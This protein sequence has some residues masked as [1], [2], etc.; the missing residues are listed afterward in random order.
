MEKSTLWIPVWLTL[1]G[2]C[3]GQVTQAPTD[4]GVAGEGGAPADSAA[5]GPAQGGQADS[6]Y[7]ID[8]SDADALWGPPSRTCPE[9][10]C[11][12]SD[13]YFP[14]IPLLRSADIGPDVTF[15]RISQ[16]H[17]L[18]VT[19]TGDVL[20][21]RLPLAPGEPPTLSK[22]P[23]A[24]TLSP[25]DVASSP[26]APAHHGVLACDDGCHVFVPSEQDESVLVAHGAGQVPLPGDPDALVLHAGPD[27][28][29]VFC[30]LGDGVVCIRNGAWEVWVKPGSGPRLRDMALGPE[31]TVLV[32]DG[33]RR[34]TFEGGLQ[35]SNP[36]E[37][38]L[39]PARD[40]ALVTP[41]FW[42]TFLVVGH[43]PTT[44]WSDD[45]DHTWSCEVPSLPKVL[46]VREVNGELHG[47]H[48]GGYPFKETLAEG[49]WTWVDACPPEGAP[50]HGEFID[51]D[52]M[53][54]GAG[55]NYIGLQAKAVFG[56]V[57]CPMVP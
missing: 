31:R 42:D 57:H 1:L 46:A 53:V 45:P 47:V 26:H 17:V 10:A 2:A 38:W 12:P 37:G 9:R 20:T 11:V 36:V 27:Q 29:P 43:D 54:C 7:P 25:K 49:R 14:E 24:S 22:L 30:V 8:G 41:R 40:A 21:A 56:T 51:A 52:V 15:L 5:D 48:A 4:G 13:N 28:E 34:V 33:G 55:I 32:G 16:S 6:G 44:I 23:S 35:G 39:E 18:A 3:G 19:D 50:F